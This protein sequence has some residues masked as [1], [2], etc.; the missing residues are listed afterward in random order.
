M[1]EPAYGRLVVIAGPMF[2]GK[3]TE[4]LRRVHRARRARIPVVV[5]TSALG[6]SA[7]VRSHDGLAERAGIID[8]LDVPGSSIP[9]QVEGTGARLVAIDEAQFLRRWHV[10][11]IRQLLSRG[12]DVICAGLDLDYAGMP[13]GPMPSLMAFADEV[14]KLSAVCVR[15]G[16]DA[17]RTQRL[18]GGRPAGPGPLILSGAEHYEPRCAACWVDPYRAREASDAG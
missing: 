12:I 14:V 8:D 9:Q 13:F 15:C 5:L 3:S 16:R 18:D 10:R 7:D 1:R 6:H 17:N 2:A 11:Q 4:L